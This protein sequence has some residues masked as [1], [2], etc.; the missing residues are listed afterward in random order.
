MMMLLAVAASC[1]SATLISASRG[2]ELRLQPRSNSHGVVIADA[3][4]NTL[5]SF[6]K[7]GGV[8]LSG[9]ISDLHVPTNGS[10]SV[11]I[12]SETVAHFNVSGIY[13][14]A[15]CSAN[16]NPNATIFADAIYRY[17]DY[18]DIVLESVDASTVGFNNNSLTDIGDADVGGDLTVSGATTL[19]AA[20][21]SGVLTVAGSS[22]FPSFSLNA[23]VSGAVPPTAITISGQLI[24]KLLVIRL[25]ALASQTATSTANVVFTDAIPASFRPSSSI[26]ATPMFVPGASPAFRPVMQLATTGIL[27]FADSATSNAGC[28]VSTPCLWYATTLFFVLP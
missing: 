18:D 3:D 2:E 15:G 24:G 22:V 6:S 17:S 26:A 13:G 14:C 20:S 9:G 1:V 7:K 21:V 16:P 11:I 12:G 19:D 28:E 5:A 4:G 25:P 10:L 27:T 23:N 8:T